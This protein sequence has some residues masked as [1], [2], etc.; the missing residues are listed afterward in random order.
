MKHK[1]TTYPRRDLS[2]FSVSILSVFLSVSSKLRQGG[3]GPVSMS[4][5]HGGAGGRGS[6]CLFRLEGLQV[7]AVLLL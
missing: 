3:P 6:R 2:Q 4:A 1:N 7:L 5:L